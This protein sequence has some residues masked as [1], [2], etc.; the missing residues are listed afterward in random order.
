MNP[1]SPPAKEWRQSHS[2]RRE[3]WVMRGEWFQP[4]TGRSEPPGRASTPSTL[5]VKRCHTAFLVAPPGLHVPLLANPMAH[6]MG[7][8]SVGPPGLR[9]HSVPTNRRPAASVVPFSTLLFTFWL[10]LASLS[11]AQT[12]SVTPH[13]LPSGGGLATSP[14]F[15]IHGSFGQ[16]TA[17]N[18]LRPGDPLDLR[19]GFWS[20]VI[21]WLNAPP[22]ATDD[23]VSRRPG[24]SAHVLIRQLLRNDIDPD[25]DPLSLAQVDATSALGGT[26]YRDGPWLIYQ[27]PSG[28]ALS[29]LDTFSYRVTDGTATPVTGTVRLGPF[30]P[31]TSGPPNALAIVL[32]L[33]PPPAVRLRFQGIARRTYLVQAASDPSG[34]WTTLDSVTAASN[35]RVEYTDAPTQDPRFYRLAEP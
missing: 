11:Q 22:S 28:A 14:R 27:P 1:N 5:S 32:E 7:Y 33:G 31:S 3:P 19:S 29:A 24:E 34:P 26:V 30:I 13:V 15:A 12:L 21:R 10:A 23:L 17:A 8:R 18:D 20:A 25:F 4:R 16:A 35:G 6:A 9:E 2:P